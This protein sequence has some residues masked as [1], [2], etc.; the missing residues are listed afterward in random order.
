MRTSSVRFAKHVH[1]VLISFPK[2]GGVHGE[3][4]PQPHPSAPKEIK[5]S[6]QSFLEKMNQSRSISTSAPAAP[7]VLDFFQAPARLTQPIPLEAL[8]IDLIESGGA[9]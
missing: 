7:G 3:H 4:T 2:R 6:F 9:Q 8:E 1:K 5:D